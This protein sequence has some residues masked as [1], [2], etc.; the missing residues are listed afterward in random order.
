MLPVTSRLVSSSASHPHPTLIRR[1]SLSC[2]LSLNDRWPSVPV[3]STVVHLLSFA[4]LPPIWSVSAALVAASLFPHSETSSAFPALVP[5]YSVFPHPP[6]Y[7]ECRDLSALCRPLCQRHPSPLRLFPSC[8][9]LSP[10][11]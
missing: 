6:P 2:V 5:S 10:S 3:L 4:A 8:L 11:A 1:R 7:M 9:Y